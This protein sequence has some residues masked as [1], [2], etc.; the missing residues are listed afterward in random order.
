MLVA[1]YFWTNISRVFLF[2]AAFIPTRPLGATVGD[3]LDKPHPK[4]GLDF[5]RPLASALLM[6]FIV[7]CILLLPQRAGSSHASSESA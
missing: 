5:N 2:W 3:L 4:G 6:V 1:I 7:G